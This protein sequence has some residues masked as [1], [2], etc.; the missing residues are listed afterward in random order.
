M[1]MFFGTSVAA[2]VMAVLVAGCGFSSDG[3]PRRSS[4]PDVPAP[5]TTYSESVFDPC[6]D[7]DDQIVRDAGFNPATREPKSPTGEYN[8]ACQF[9]SADMSLVISTSRTTF[10][11]FRD[12]YL[13]VREGL[14]IGKRPAVVVR[15]SEP[16][17]P[18]ELAMKAGDGIVTLQTT[19]NVTARQWGIN[20]C[21]R[22]VE[23]A[24]VIEPVIDTR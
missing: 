19:L 13:G 22:I 10:E 3:G 2:V 17:L 5:T 18:C 1:I 12:R 8:A 7:I 16:D 11:E 4:S 6:G 14:D 20:R 24:T 9:T 15:K 23:I 21:A